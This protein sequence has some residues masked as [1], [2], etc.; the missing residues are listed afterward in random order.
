MP[1]AKSALARGS[2]RWLPKHSLSW[3]PFSK[4]LNLQFVLKCHLATYQQF[5]GIV[6]ELIPRKMEELNCAAQMS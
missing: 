1:E 5:Y 3:I 2:L 6:F 4:P